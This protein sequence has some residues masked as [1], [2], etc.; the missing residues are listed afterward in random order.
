MA[1]GIDTASHKGALASGGRTIAVLPAGADR[2]YPPAQRQTLG[3]I[4]SV[5]A[6]I[7]ELPPGSEIW[8][9]TFPARNRIIAALSR[10]T[11]VV[12]AKEGS[13]ALLTAAM[14]RRLGRAL[15]AVPGRVTAPLSTG[16]NALIASGATLVRDAQDVLDLLFGPGG[17]AVTC[18]RPPPLHGALAELASAIGSGLEASQAF[19]QLGLDADAGLAALA[20]LEL[21][22]YIRREPG[23]RFALVP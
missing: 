15:A 21:G 1:N 2:P 22:G 5:G 13:G 12:E 7:S 10:A 16:P 6:A 19:E 23:G 18:E 14:A 8:R 4:R 3:R 20:E 9:W 17:R 11:V